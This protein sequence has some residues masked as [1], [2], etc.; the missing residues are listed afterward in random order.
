MSKR[1][2]KKGRKN[3]YNKEE[4]NTIICGSCNLC[5]SIKNQ[6]NCDFCYDF[7]KK[8]HKKFMNN[9]FNQLKNLNWPEEGMIQ[10][11][12]FSNIF[13]NNCKFYKSKEK[14][15]NMC[16]NF[17]VCFNDFKDQLNPVYTK[18]LN[19]G[20]FSKENLNDYLGIS[21]KKEEP[22]IVQP[23]P[24]FFYSNSLEWRE[25]LEEI[26]REL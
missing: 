6:N 13:C 17:V 20:L 7:Y 15:R 9:I 11:T 16:D 5:I 26:Y 22:F 12:V 3:K 4:F 2:K 19:A 8:D 25:E 10:I 21:K 14:D 23:Y 24:T 1:G 18:S